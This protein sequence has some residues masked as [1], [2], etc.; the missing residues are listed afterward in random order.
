M[1]ALFFY[2]LKAVFFRR[3]WKSLC[4]FQIQ[5]SIYGGF[6]MYVYVCMYMRLWNVCLCEE[7]DAILGSRF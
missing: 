3:V 1:L 2:F 7:M 4:K 6:A 5:H